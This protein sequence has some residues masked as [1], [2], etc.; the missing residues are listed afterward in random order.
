M[1]SLELTR[2]REARVKAAMATHDAAHPSADPVADLRDAALLRAEFAAAWR[3]Y[4]AGLADLPPTDPARCRLPRPAG[5]EGFE[6]ARRDPL[7]LTE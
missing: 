7:A 5:V 6:G 2:R 3:E 4:D 1:T